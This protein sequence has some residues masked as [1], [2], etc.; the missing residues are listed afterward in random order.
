[1]GRLVAI[2]NDC[3]PS[4]SSRRFPLRRSGTRPH[5]WPRPATPTPFAPATLPFVSKLR[6]STPGLR[7]S[8]SNASASGSSSHE[9][10][11]SLHH[12]LDLGKLSHL[13]Y[14]EFVMCSIIYPV[15][16]LRLFCRE[17]FM[18]DW[19]LRCFYFSFFFCS[20]LILVCLIILLCS[21][22]WFEFLYRCLIWYIDI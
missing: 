12:Q 5:Y 1:M 11:F 22:Q 7:Q 10:Y 6:H 17:I 19:S 16:R 2:L 21:F 14:M 15:A 20:L 18:Y 9:T 8:W 4:Q 13:Y 3:L